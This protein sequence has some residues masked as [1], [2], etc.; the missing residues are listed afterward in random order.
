MA[1]DGFI[2][3]ESQ[4][5]ALENKKAENEAKGEIHTEYPGYLGSQNMYYVGNFKRIG[6]VYTQTF[7]DSYSR[8]I[9]AK[10]YAEK[11]PITSADMLNDRVLPW[12]EHEAVSVL[13]VFTD[14]G[15]EYKS[16]IENHAYELY[17][18]VQ[19]YRA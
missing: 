15:T 10:L 12:Y 18:S 14:R 16:V 19:W 8:V 4:Q 17:L 11:T 7:I 9:D 2:L 5:V 6:N 13:R 3:T 1:Q